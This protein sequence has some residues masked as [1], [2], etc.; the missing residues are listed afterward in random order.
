M[1][2]PDGLQWVRYDQIQRGTRRVMDCAGHKVD[3][4]RAVCEANEGVHVLVL[5]RSD[6]GNGYVFSDERSVAEF[7]AFLPGAKVV[8][9]EPS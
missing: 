1:I 7:Y 9:E 4:V 2:L 8:I 5:A 6:D 3:R